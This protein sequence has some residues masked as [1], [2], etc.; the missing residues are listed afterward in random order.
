MKSNASPCTGL[1]QTQKTPSSVIG[2][3]AGK[4]G[5]QAPIGSRLAKLDPAEAN[6]SMEESLRALSV[7]LK[8]EWQWMFPTDRGAYQALRSI[9][10]T[11]GDAAAVQKALSISMAF[12]EPAP[13]VELDA[14]LAELALTTATRAED[15]MDTDAKMRIYARK[16]AE[17]PADLVRATLQGWPKTKNGTW[18]P[19]LAELIE[20]LEGPTAYR[21]SVAAQIRNWDTPEGRVKRIR[22]LQKMV[23]EARFDA[24]MAKDDP[25]RKAKIEAC[26]DAWKA[27]IERLKS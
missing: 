26:M 16:L 22:E 5:S 6:R 14:W 13:Q 9:K 17:Y 1:A 21:Q 25:A 2:A 10:V 27:E 12:L 7:E 4:S 11:V 15:S 23:D 20:Q 24:R 8:S 18:W 19:K 3:V